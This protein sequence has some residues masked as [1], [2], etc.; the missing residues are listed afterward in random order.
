MAAV[1][2]TYTL[3]VSAQATNIST[4]SFPEE[5]W[6]G[7]TEKP[8]K[9][10]DKLV[11]YQRIFDAYNADNK[12]KYRTMM[13]GLE[14]VEGYIRIVSQNMHCR[15]K[16]APGDILSCKGEYRFR[17]NQ[18]ARAIEFAKRIQSGTMRAS[19]IAIQELQD[20]EAREAF[21][22]QMAT[23]PNYEVWFP[24]A[25]TRIGH[26]MVDLADLPSGQGYVW[27]KTKVK[28]LEKTIWSFP[29]S[30]SSGADALTADWSFKGMLWGRFETVPKAGQSKYTFSVFNI[31]PSPYVQSVAL[32]RS[33]Y[34]I[35][36]VS[37]HLY[38]FTLA[39]QKIEEIITEQRRATPKIYEAM[40]IVGDWNVNK[41]FQN[42]FSEKTMD[43]RL[44]LPAAAAAAANNKPNNTVVGRGMKMVKQTRNGKN[45]ETTKVIE[46]CF[47]DDIPFTGNKQCDYAACCGSEYLTCLEILGAV[48][49]THLYSLS[50]HDK[51]IPAPYAG[52]YTWD[53][54][55]NSV[56]FS[57]FWS[58]RMFQMLDHITYLKDGHIP[59][60]AH[61][62]TK[63]YLTTEPVRVDEGPLSYPCRV[64]AAGVQALPDNFLPYSRKDV[65]IENK[66][67]STERRVT[68]DQHQY[69]DLADHYAVECV[70]ILSYNEPA[71][72][73]TATA[74]SAFYEKAKFWTDSFFPHAGSRTDMPALK[75]F[76]MPKLWQFVSTAIDQTKFET[77]KTSMGVAKN[78][79]R[80][81]LITHIKNKAAVF[82]T[83][84]PE[85]VAASYMTQLPKSHN[86][87]VINDFVFKMANRLLEREYINRNVI[88]KASVTGKFTCATKG[89]SFYRCSVTR[90]AKGASTPR[91]RIFKKLDIGEMKDFAEAY[92][93][94]VSDGVAPVK[95]AELMK[96]PAALAAHLI[97]SPLKMKT[98]K[99]PA[100]R[101]ASDTISLLGSVMEYLGGGVAA[102]SAGL[103]GALDA[104]DD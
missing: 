104:G 28:S 82:K 43:P 16:G 17:D 18:K 5:W 100:A 3:A 20:T 99:P 101:R 68:Y 4:G 29:S 15:D 62:M 85:H 67:K 51:D 8:K 54:L 12:D 9:Y 87:S 40:F 66:G 64:S 103:S 10:N 48:P 97:P 65:F 19:V 70:A 63:R 86:P 88:G 37:S 61:T 36:I 93:A 72:T 55:V 26:S 22:A 73:A 41:F 77:T 91:E 69:V 21:I 27:D 56:M 2:D 45:I 39:A 13:T 42:G 74:V 89:N 81:T 59:M 79:K 25:Y 46:T 14:S 90:R 60:Y 92:A 84:L 50:E 47:R 83:R 38:Q 35:E 24:N 80:D 30:V 102:T 78:V 32:P 6:D 23:T 44:G 52:K 75:N 98:P 31:H 1:A 53:G 95:S 96:T 76:M 71:V 49:P 33:K 11:E 34:D 58:S 7:R 94:L 57:P